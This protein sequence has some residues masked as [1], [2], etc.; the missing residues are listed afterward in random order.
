MERKTSIALKRSMVLK[1]DEE[2]FG[3][4]R[5]ESNGRLR[6]ESLPGSR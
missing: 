1:G 2:G 4:G 5:K 3:G 6:N